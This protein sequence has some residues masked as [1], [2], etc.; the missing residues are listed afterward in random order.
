MNDER[1]EKAGVELS[2]RIIKC[3]LRRLKCT[4][5]DLCLKTGMQQSYVSR[6]LHGHNSLTLAHTIQLANLC[7]MVSSRLIAEAE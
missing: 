3:A 6:I 7:G 4:Q 2:G 1:S 5:R